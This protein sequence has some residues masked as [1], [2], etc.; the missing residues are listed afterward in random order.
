M[1]KSL[2][3][4]YIASKME[5]LIASQITAL[6]LKSKN[7]HDEKV[8]AKALG[9]SA[10]YVIKMRTGSV[11]F[12]V[13]Q[14]SAIAAVFGVGLMIK[15]VP[16]QEMLDF[17]N[18]YSQ[19]DFDIKDKIEDI[20]LLEGAFELWAKLLTLGIKPKKYDLPSPWELV[21]VGDL[22]GPWSDEISWREKKK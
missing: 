5:I 3:A 11:D 20:D 15:F 7:F 12:N 6:R 10:E 21:K 1:K 9:V 8:L 22:S 16:L 19:D 18:S 2:R 13:E 14:L 17:D 4:S